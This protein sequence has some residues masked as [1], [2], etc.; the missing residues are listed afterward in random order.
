MPS[1]GWSAMTMDFQ[2]K[3]KAELQGLEPPQKVT[4]DLI[5]GNNGQ[6]LITR[7]APAKQVTCQLHFLS[8]S[9]RQKMSKLISWKRIA[10]L[11]GLSIIPAAQAADNNHEMSGSTGKS[12]NMSGMNMDQHLRQMQDN[13]IKMHE[14]MHQIE[15]A[16]TPQEKERLKAE[17]REVMRKNM[18]GM[19][20]MKSGMEGMG[21]MGNM[22]GQSNM[23][24][25][26]SMNSASPKNSGDMGGMQM[27]H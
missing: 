22:Q 16:K 18:M 6:Y 23:E 1:L 25:G 10:L 13:M 27:G 3:H 2:T 19:K 7:L 26:K 12:G 9:R 20:Q 4:F 8:Q 14:F 15:N 21:G 5:K 24:P 11:A 17:Q